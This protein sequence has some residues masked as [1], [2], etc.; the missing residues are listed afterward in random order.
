M[1][2][3]PSPNADRWGGPGASH[4]NRD[5]PKPDPTV[6]DADDPDH[7]SHHSKISGGGGESD[8]HHGHPAN[9]KRDFEA[10]KAEKSKDRSQSS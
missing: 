1:S 2:H 8:L 4:E 10:G 7:Y 3:H 6:K 5:K 9:L